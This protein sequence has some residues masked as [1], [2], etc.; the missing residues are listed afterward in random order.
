[1]TT[2]AESGVNIAAGDAA[3]KNA[4]K[5]AKQT[6]AGRANMIGA[7]VIQDGG[8]SGLLDMGNF[9]LTQCCDTVGTKITIA[10]KIKKF[11]GL[12][13]DLL[14]MVAD[15]A[16]CSGAET[17]SITNTFETTAIEPSE[18]SAMMESLSKACQEQKVVIPGGEIAE[19]GDMTNGTGWGADA[20]GV[21]QK[22]RVIT[23]ENIAAGQKIVGLKG[24]AFRCN[25]LSL[26]RRICANNFGPDWETVEYQDGKTW[27]EVL[28]TPSKIFQRAILE[29]VIG[30]FDGEKKYDVHGI[31]HVTGGGIPGNLPRIFN[32]QTLG[33][34]LDNLHAP[35]DALKKLKEL[36]NVADEEAY[37][38]WNSG[39]AMMLIV[40]EADAQNIADALNAYDQEIQAQIVGEINTTGK[41]E[42]ISQYTHNTLTFETE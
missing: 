1:M 15:D 19:V 30:T 42:L 9:Y 31:V 12:G 18:I 28:L 14:C 37:R 33:A 34:K 11:D 20:V 3:S 13:Q 40:D 32:D 16:I 25:G 10:E 29:A 2:Y 23:G 22:D 27:G 39:T 6:F 24:R 8:F 17:V 35:H 21:V 36:G 4:Y 38:T 26:A 7:P 41:I 5:F